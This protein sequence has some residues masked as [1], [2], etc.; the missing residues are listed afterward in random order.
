MEFD[1]QMSVSQQMVEN[2]L[3]DFFQ[4]KGL[5]EAMRYSLLAGGKRIRP[6][7]TMQFCQAAGGRPEEALDF[8]CGL[9]MLHTYSLIHDDLP[10]MDNDD[11]RRG[12]PTC[13]KMFGECIATL[14]GDALQS[15]AFRTV[16]SATG[17]WEEDSTVP[18]KAALTLAEAAGELGM[19]DGQYWDTM[20]DGKPHT[21]EEL[22]AIH[23]NKTG[24]LL[25]AACEMGVLASSGHRKVDPCCLEAAREYATELGMAFQIQD[26]I[27]DAVSTTET[28]GKPV[29]SD[30]AN[31]KT[32]FVTLVGVESCRELVQQHTQKAKDALKKGVWLGD[33]GFLCWLADLLAQRSY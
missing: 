31:S 11:L 3:A 24:A 30:E 33:T 29:G 1:K 6:V 10:C 5:E 17:P 9:E 19:C 18:G 20:G 25:R 16:L 7:L 15:A 26:D 28:L 32:T 22:T 8:G 14:A 2:R 21:M 13:H 4:K 12:K 27:L 23:N